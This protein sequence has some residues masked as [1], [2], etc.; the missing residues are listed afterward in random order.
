MKEITICLHCGSSKEVVDNQMRLLKP[1]ENDFI[2][3]WNNRID[4]HPE[5][6]DSFSELI[7]DCIVTSPTDIDLILFDAICYFLI[8]NIPY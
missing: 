7:N 2:I 6:Y 3:H 1:L 5:T 8:I 4:R